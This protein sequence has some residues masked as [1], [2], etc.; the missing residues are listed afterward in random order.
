MQALWN[1]GLKVHV[2]GKDTAD[3]TEQLNTKEVSSS[4]KDYDSYFSYRGDMSKDAKKQE[5]REKD[6]L[7]LV[8]HYYNLVTDFYEYG[9]GQS[10]HFA[11]R[12]EG[13]TF[14]ESI[15]RHEYYLASRIQA[16]PGQVL[17]D[18]GCGVGGPL[19]NIARFSQAKVVGVNNNEY[20]C[21]R[22]QRLN[23]KAGLQHLSDV[24]KGDFMNL[25]FPDN[26]FDGVYA[27]EATCHSSDR[28]QTFQNVFRVCK[29]GGYFGCYEWGMTDKYDAKNERHRKIK[30][31][32]EYG[33]SL[34]ILVHI[35]EIIENARQ[36]GFEVIEAFDVA[37]TAKE[38]GQTI[39]WHSTL[40]GGWQ[41][42]N[43]LRMSKPGRFITQNMVTIL[44]KFRI[45]PTGTTQTHD[46][47]CVAAD[48]L[49]DGGDLEIFTPM[50]FILARKPF[51]HPQASP[52]SST[53]STCTP[54][55]KKKSTKANKKD[56]E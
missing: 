54:S 30:H 56:Q 38:A 21:K 25:P 40:K 27:I 31:G 42:L 6:V 47:L 19:R 10:F 24:V 51:S 32:I 55:T 17:L 8:N 45:A 4:I 26:H 35:N 23:E 15:A 29:E 7:K 53:T 2:P 22:T 46:M 1:L 44:E 39:G 20:Q 41:S 52:S 3:V 9:W 36:A 50:L 43:G 33:N 37:E 12:F 28:V 5:S 13:E 34:P 49:A 48:N 18:V 16:K 11:P 14:N